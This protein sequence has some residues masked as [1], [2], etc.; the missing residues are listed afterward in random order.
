[1]LTRDGCRARIS[2]LLDRLDSGVEALLLARAE[3]VFYFSNYMSA[4]TN[5]HHRAPQYLLIE[6]DGAATLVLDGW[7][8]PEWE[9]WAE[10]VVDGGWGVKSPAE[11][12]AA[13]AAQAAVDLLRR[14]GYRTVGVES[15]HLN[16]TV[17]QAIADP[18]DVEP[19]IE[20]MRQVKDPDEL[21]VIRAAMRVGEAGHAAAHEL[22]APG[23]RE[24]D[25]YSQVVAH[26]TMAAA[27]PLVMMCDFGS[28]PDMRGGPPTTRRIEAGDNVVLDLFPYV[29]GYRCDL[30]NT[31]N[32]G[33]QPSREQR[34][35]FET[36]VEALHASE[37]VVTPGISAREVFEAQDSVFRKANP[38]W[39][40]THHAGHSLGLEHPEPPDFRADVDTPILEGMVITLEP[41]VY[42]RSFHGVRVEHN[43]LVTADGLERLSNHRL[44]LT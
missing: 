10:A 26:A 12:R 13:R 37:R 11:T 5:N 33:A 42:G 15:S 34:E 29:Y 41:G 28:G 44:S 31:L 8:A 19:Q 20:E 38:A 36:A 32:A 7:A 43:Y 6:R 24:I 23:M 9:Q 4:P 14:R 16:G 3:H 39:R 21:A 22:L 17:A 2:R 27:Q 1:M 18:V 30:T 25:F 35:A 40:L